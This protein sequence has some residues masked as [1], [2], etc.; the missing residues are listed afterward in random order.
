MNMIYKHCYNRRC[1][2][3]FPTA[4]VLLFWVSIQILN[5]TEEMNPFFLGQ[6]IMDSNIQNSCNLCGAN[7]PA[8]VAQDEPLVITRW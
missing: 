3:F 5:E 8:V 6:S 7:G 4:A 2:Q 1:E